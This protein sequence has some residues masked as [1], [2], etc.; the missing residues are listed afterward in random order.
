MCR[1][2]NSVITNVS[3]VCGAYTF[4]EL[5]HIKCVYRLARECGRCVR[6]TLAA[7]TA[8]NLVRPH[9]SSSRPF[10]YILYVSVYIKYDDVMKY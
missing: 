10:I 4:S 8:R 2:S 3:E 9:Y 7:M 1:F 6:Y 5:R